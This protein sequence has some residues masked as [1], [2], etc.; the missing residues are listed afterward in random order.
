M[1]RNIREVIKMEDKLN[2]KKVAF[3]LAGISGVAYIICAILVAISPVGTVKVFRYL[4]H[5]IDISKIATTPTLANSILGFFEIVILALFVG[6]LF[7][8]IYNKQK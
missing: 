4:F 8:W 6:W 2:T 7:A 3:S 1:I 5:G